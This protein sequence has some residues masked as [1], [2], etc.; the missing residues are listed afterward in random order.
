M[1]SAVQERQDALEGKELRLA[2]SMQHAQQLSQLAQE[3][4]A[5]VGV[6]G[7]AVNSG[8]ANCVAHATA[9]TVA[10]VAAGPQE[11][12][13]PRAGGIA[14]QL[15]CCVDLPADD[16]QALL[17]DSPSPSAAVAAAGDCGSSSDSSV[18][19]GLLQKAGL[20]VEQLHAALSAGEGLEG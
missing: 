2:R 20:V 14:Q 4:L 12:D 6:L 10:A 17:E 13:A 3:L 19:P 18:L 16:I 1:Q 15:A 5:M 7:G 8:A 11:A 9:T